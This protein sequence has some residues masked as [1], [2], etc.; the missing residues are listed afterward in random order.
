[1]TLIDI[2]SGPAIFQ[3]F[4]GGMS[5][6]T[7]PYKRTMSMRICVCTALK[8]FQSAP[9]CQ[10]QYASVQCIAACLYNMTYFVCLLI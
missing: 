10:K 4:L 9:A 2:P 6:F 7:L 8:L 5:R 1:M 3:G